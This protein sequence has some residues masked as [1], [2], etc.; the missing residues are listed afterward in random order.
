MDYS[1]GLDALQNI[2]FSTP[3][4]NRTLINFFRPALSIIFIKNLFPGII[5]SSQSNFPRAYI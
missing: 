3:T 1:I 2:K 4:G 5:Y